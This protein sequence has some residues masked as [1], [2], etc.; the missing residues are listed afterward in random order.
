MKLEIYEISSFCCLRFLPFEFEFRDHPDGNQP[1]NIG[2]NQRANGAATPAKLPIPFGGRRGSSPSREVRRAA[3]A[4]R[5]EDSLW[6]RSTVDR[7][8]TTRAE[9][10]LHSDLGAKNCLWF[11]RV[12]RVFPT[13]CV[14]CFSQNCVFL[15]ESTII[16]VKH[17]RPG[18]GIF[19][20][21][22]Q[23]LHSALH[24]RS[25]LGL[26]ASSHA[27]FP[28]VFLQFLRPSVTFPTV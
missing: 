23:Y 8:S 18:R 1:P 16:K 11:S 27:R 4:C 22:L 19:T 20:P 5:V 6:S 15:K 12:A 25:F 24:L 2:E 26:C 17:H 21:R 14:V 28:S 7:E 10:R 13:S 3:S 9:R